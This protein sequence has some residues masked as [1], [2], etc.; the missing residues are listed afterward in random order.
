MSAII[1]IKD[2]QSVLIEQYSPLVNRIANFL[3]LP[4][5]EIMQ[6]SDLIQVGMIGLI[7]AS[8]NYVETKGATRDTYYNIWIRGAMLDEIR[9]NVWSPRSVGLKL[10]MIDSAKSNVENSAFHIASDRDIAK[11]LRLS[12]PEYSK[13]LADSVA[14]TQIGYEDVNMKESYFSSGLTDTTPGPS[15]SLQNEDYKRSF[16][17]LISELPKQ[18]RKVISLYYY[19]DLDQKQISQI[20]DVSESRISQ[21]RKSALERLKKHKKQFIEG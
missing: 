17:T 7:K 1:K 11:E 20:M 15:D 13:V 12:L 2:E 10:R 14:Q 18:E 9:R 21:I 19:Q 4:F 3:I 16:A 8:D 6:V 5:K